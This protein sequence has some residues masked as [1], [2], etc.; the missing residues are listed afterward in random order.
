[1]VPARA[2]LPAC[3][4]SSSRP[5][6]SDRLATAVRASRSAYPARALAFAFALALTGMPRPDAVA[7]ADE[8]DLPGGEFPVSGY[9][10]MGELVRALQDDG[11]LNPGLF[12]VEH[13]AELWSTVEGTAGSSCATCHGDAAQSMRGVAARYPAYDPKQGRLVNLELR[14]NEMRT[15]YMGAPGPF[16]WNRRRCSRLPPS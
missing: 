6:P 8:P 1:M 15:E 2:V 7:V 9:H 5:P 3:V 14:I 10:Y 16:P 13:G 4:A 12:A 11:F